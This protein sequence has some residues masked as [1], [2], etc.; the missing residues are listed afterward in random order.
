MNHVETILLRSIFRTY[1]KNVNKYGRPYDLILQNEWKQ[2][3]IENLDTLSIIRLVTRDE[4]M[5]RE[6]KLD[7]GFDLL[8]K[9]N[10]TYILFQ[11]I[12]D[13]F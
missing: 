11:H 7:Y 8:R 4:K 9:M 5:K 10:K 2:N 6:E 13:I 12:H 3:G 1:K